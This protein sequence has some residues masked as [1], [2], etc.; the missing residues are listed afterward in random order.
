[1]KTIKLIAFGIA[2]FLASATQAQISFSVH[3]GTPPQWGPEGYSEARYYYLP[4][5]EAYYDVQTSRFIYL[6]GR[7]WVHRTYLPARYRNY[8]LYN[9]YKVVMTDYHGNTP[10]QYHKQYRV[11]Y[12]R[13][14]RGHEQRNIGHRP[15]IRNRQQINRTQVRHSNNYTKRVIQ[16]SDNRRGND[17][18]RDRENNRKDHK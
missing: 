10:Y 18:H 16:R 13:G 11:K 1:M 5:V 17:E 14:Y 6:V 2:L 3:L 9:G 7:T 8:D 4:D 12:A 15:E